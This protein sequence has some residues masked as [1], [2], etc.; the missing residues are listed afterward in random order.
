RADERELLVQ[1]TQGLT[2]HRRR[3]EESI[4]HLGFLLAPEGALGR[5]ASQR[6]IWLGYRAVT[7]A[8]RRRIHSSVDRRSSRPL[9]EAN[10]PPLVLAGAGSGALVAIF[11]CL[12]GWLAMCAAIIPNAAARSIGDMA[13]MAIASSRLVAR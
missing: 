12:V 1:N 9:G 3:G 10:C 6:G 2:S 7:C 13:S 4:G 8:L 5:D 11:G